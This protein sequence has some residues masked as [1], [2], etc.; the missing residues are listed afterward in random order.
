MF[1]ASGFLITSCYPL[2]VWLAIQMSSL[3]RTVSRQNDSSMRT[4]ASTSAKETR[5]TLYSGSG[6][7]E[8]RF[9]LLVK[10]F[11]FIDVPAT[12]SALVGIS[13]KHLSLF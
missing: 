12:G 8:H 6:E 11:Q 3:T 4:G 2:G 9:R 5:Q 7:G 13:Q 1:L 10:L